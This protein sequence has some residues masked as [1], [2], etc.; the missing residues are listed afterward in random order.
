MNDTG[1]MSFEE[2]LFWVDDVAEIQRTLEDQITDARIWARLTPDQRE[3]ILSSHRTNH[4]LLQAY[5][6]Y[7]LGFL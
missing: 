4:L 3:L 1:D 7:I 6:T 5:R 2:F